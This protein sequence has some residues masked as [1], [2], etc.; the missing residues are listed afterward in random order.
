MGRV[1]MKNHHIKND[2]PNHK[3]CNINL[4]ST[5]N[6]YA[7]EQTI[8]KEFMIAPL[9]TKFAFNSELCS[10]NLKTLISFFVFRR[11]IVKRSILS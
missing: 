4:Y 8:C 11:A 6:H 5:S 9:T 7:N 3:K 2:Y 10:L 1:P